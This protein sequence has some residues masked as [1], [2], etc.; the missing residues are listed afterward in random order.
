MVYFTQMRERATAKHHEGA[1]TQQPLDSA[2]A[3]FCASLENPNTKAANRS[4]L[5]HFSKFAKSVALTQRDQLTQDLIND[6]LEYCQKS[7]LKASTI[8][9]RFVVIKRFLE[10]SGMGELAEQTRKIRVQH[11]RNVE[12][13][14]PLHPLSN[15][16][17]KSLQEASQDNPRAS[18]IIA[19]ALGT[20]ATLE[21]LRALNVSD[22]LEKESQ[23]VAVRFRGKKFKR[24]ITLNVHASEIVKR[25]RGDR[26]GEE[27][28]FSEKTPV[29]L[30]ERLGREGIWT[31]VKQYAK[32]IGR[33][34]LN[35]R[36]L[37]QTFIMN[38][39][40]KDSKELAKLLG[41]GGDYAY[42]VLLER[43]RL[44]QPLPES[45]VL[46]EATA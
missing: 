46:F 15:E 11:I 18:A 14:Q 28:L 45:V 32:K 5:T 8:N 10:Q 39:G 27:P 3:R 40:V 23:R 29:K 13:L 44:T 33:P 2:I 6:Y 4:D 24:E 35:L 43:R 12:E 1:Q 17:I 36:V 20:G 22:I 30:G 26:E 25:Y 37:R 41:V 42:D 21:Q 16:E 9:R 7:G 19:I 31:D 34:D 38:V